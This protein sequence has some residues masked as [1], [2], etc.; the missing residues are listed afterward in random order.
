MGIRGFGIVGLTEF[1]E[2][3]DIINGPSYKKNEDKAMDQIHQNIIIAA[4]Q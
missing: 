1:D 4:F 2:D 3:N